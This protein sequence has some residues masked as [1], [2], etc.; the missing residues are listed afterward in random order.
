MFGFQV[1]IVMDKFVLVYPVIGDLIMKLPDDPHH[2]PVFQFPSDT[3]FLDYSNRFR[4]QYN[5]TKL[6][7]LSITSSGT[8]VQEKL[9]G[10]YYVH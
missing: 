2:L 9:T 5:I 1:M 3:S 7:Q 4:L 8:D 10:L 6:L